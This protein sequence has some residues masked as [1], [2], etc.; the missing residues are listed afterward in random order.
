MNLATNGQV[1][2]GYDHGKT[3]AFDTNKTIVNEGNQAFYKLVLRAKQFYNYGTIQSYNGSF[4][5][6]YGFNKGVIK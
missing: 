1:Y 2:T 4:A 6:Y 5:H 3:F